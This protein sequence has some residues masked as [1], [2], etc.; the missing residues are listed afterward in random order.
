MIASRSHTAAIY[1]VFFPID[2][3]ICPAK[4]PRSPIGEYFLKIT[5]PSFS[6]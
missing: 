3:Q 5:S 1:P 6:V 4:S 2:S